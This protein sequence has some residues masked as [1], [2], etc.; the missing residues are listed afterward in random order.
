MLAEHFL[1][2]FRAK[3]GKPVERID[4]RSHE[5]LLAIPGP[6]TCAS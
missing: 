2:R 3:Y 5:L 1:Q 4:P 6:G